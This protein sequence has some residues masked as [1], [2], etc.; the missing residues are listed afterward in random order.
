MIRR[1]LYTGLFAV[2][3]LILAGCSTAVLKPYREEGSKIVEEASSATS[4][5]RTGQPVATSRSPSVHHIDGGVYIPVRKIAVSK[6][7]HP[8]T[9]PALQRQITVNRSF[10]SAQ[11]IAERITGLTGI[12]A[13][14]APDVAQSSQNAMTPMQSAGAALPLKIPSSTFLKAVNLCSL[15][16]KSASIRRALRQGSRTRCANVRM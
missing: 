9:D 7:F 5:M 2:S 3:G 12:P 15:R 1:S 16:E 10:S 8:A 13:I 6:T 4:A 14:I 11:E